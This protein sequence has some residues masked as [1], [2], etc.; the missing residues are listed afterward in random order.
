MLTEYIQYK[1]IHIGEYLSYISFVVIGY[2]LPTVVVYMYRVS[3]KKV[4]NKFFNFG[5]LLVFWT[6]IDN[7][8]QITQIWT[9]L[10]TLDP[11]GPF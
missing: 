3:Q 7:F 4:S 6:P 10:A 5:L 8:G 2:I 9:F 1:Y 11:F